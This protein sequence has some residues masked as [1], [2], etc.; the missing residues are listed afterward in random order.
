[1]RLINA[2]WE[3]NITGLKTCEI[4][5]EKGDRLQTYLDST[6]EERFDFCVVKIPAGDLNLVHQMEDIGYRY[7]ENQITISFEADQTEKIDK[8]WGRLLAG[9]TYSLVTTEEQIES[10]LAEVNSKMFENDRIS[11]DPYFT[12]HVSSKRYTG[13]IKEM[14]EKNNADFYIMKKCNEDAGF[15]SIKNVSAK[16]CNCPIAGIYNKFKA[17]GY[18]FAL[19]WF[20]LT[21]SKKSGY[22]K[23]QT[24]I[25]TNNT[26]IHSFLSK[27]FFFRI[28]ETMIVLRKL[29]N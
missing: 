28:D 13:W 23:L 10:I 1:M 7:L 25:S 22:M 18:F 8:K 26:A 6:A 14:Y 4:I 27:I 12:N 9:F 15:F 29:I 5:F 17:H 16:V 3:E 19:T 20:W 2:L 21:E 11:L 24:S